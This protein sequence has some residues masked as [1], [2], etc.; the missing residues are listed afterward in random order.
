MNLIKSNGKE[1]SKKKNNNNNKG[2]KIL[3]LVVKVMWKWDE[4]KL[5]VVMYILFAEIKFY[6]DRV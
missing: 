1:N 4:A 5:W 3:T 6:M 2:K